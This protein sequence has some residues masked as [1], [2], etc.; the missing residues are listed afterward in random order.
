M[1]LG[2]IFPLNDKKHTS[3]PEKVK[4]LHENLGKQVRMDS[5][6][7]ID[8]DG[9]FAAVIHVLQTNTNN[10]NYQIELSNIN[11]EL[12]KLNEKTLG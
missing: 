6:N 11:D 7:P 5:K 4:L 1:L 8:I 3:D 2:L 10:V 9:N 12:A